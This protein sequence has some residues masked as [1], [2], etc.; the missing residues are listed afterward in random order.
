MKFIPDWSLIPLLVGIF[1]AGILG[2]LIGRSLLK[3]QFERAGI[4]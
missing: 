2:A 1:I 4:V 3:K